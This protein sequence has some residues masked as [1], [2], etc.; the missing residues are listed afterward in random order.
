M[1]NEEKKQRAEYK[2]FR[3]KVISILLSVILVVTLAATTFAIIYYQM[4]KTY[5]INYHENSSIDYKVYLKENDFYEED[6]LEKGQAYVATL[7][8]NVV[9]DFDYSFIMDASDV[10][11]EY[12]YF[13]DAQ[14]EIVDGSSKTAI[15]NP[16]YNL[17]EKKT[18]NQ[19]NKNSFRVTEQVKIDYD[20]Y[21]DLAN[22]FLSTYELTNTTSTLIVKAHISVLSICE[23]LEENSENEY[24]IALRIPLTS[25]TV[26][27]E[28]TSNVPTAGSRLLA[29]DRG[30]SRNAFK[31]LAIVLF[32]L[33]GIAIISFFAFAYL[34]RNQ[35]INYSIKVKKILNSYKPYIQQINNEFDTTGYQVLLVNTFNE[36]LEIRDT[37]QSPILMHEDEDQTQTKFIIANDTKILYMYEIRVEMKEDYVIGTEEE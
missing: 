1:S 10:N 28:M 23:D 6:Y 14:L 34:T 16:V 18:V 27:V 3:N 13:I 11:Y 8:G 2:K 33:D 36:M 30:E 24:V 9:I 35:D 25:K 20:Q 21:N 32:V 31:V 5:Y 4:N 29:C 19:E 17:K 37:L 12:S 15:F 22:K 7:I 26:N